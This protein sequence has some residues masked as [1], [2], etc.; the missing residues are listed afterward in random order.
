MVWS[1]QALGFEGALNMANFAA[2]AAGPRMR[3]QI[4]AAHARILWACGVRE[5][6]K[7]ATAGR[8]DAQEC[9][10]CDERVLTDTDELAVQC[11]DHGWFCT[12]ECRSGSA[13]RRARGPR[14]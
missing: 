14:T 7:L 4:D 8:P 10:H 9:A 2:S 3:A 5:G 1:S 12:P 6:F 13:A 11:E